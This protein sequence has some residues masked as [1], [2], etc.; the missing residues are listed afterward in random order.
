MPGP[1]VA[2]NV[3]RSVLAVPSVQRA[4]TRP[5]IE[6]LVRDLAGGRLRLSAGS[7]PSGP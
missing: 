1:F 2:D 6:I 4:G 3:S 5:G 7:R